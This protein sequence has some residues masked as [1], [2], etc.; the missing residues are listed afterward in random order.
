MPRKCR[1]KNCSDPHLALG[2][3]NKHYSRVK[4]LGTPYL[5]PRPVCKICGKEHDSLGY[6]RNHYRQL[7]WYPKH[8]GYSKRYRPIRSH[9]CAAPQC[10]H[11]ISLKRQYCFQHQ[12][13]KQHNLTLDLSVDCRGISNRGEKNF[14]WRGG[15]FEYPNHYLMKKNRLIILMNNPKCEVCGKTATC[16]HHRNGDKSDHRLEN[17]M[18]SCHRCNARIRF[19]PNNT[20]YS[21]LYGLR[22]HEMTKKFGHSPTFYH[23]LHYQGKLSDYL[24]GRES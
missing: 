3:C 23:Q 11:R 6:C 14:Q 22:L 13:R 20:K 7:I 21:R 8:R 24:K 18:P 4:R 16:I 1:I 17:L 2:Y 19:G 9:A 10:S 5:P 12:R 15:V